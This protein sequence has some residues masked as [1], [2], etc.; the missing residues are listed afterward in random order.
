MA[1]INLLLSAR[2]VVLSVP[3]PCLPLSLPTLCRIKLENKGH[4]N[5]CGLIFHFARR[6]VV[7]LFADSPPIKLMTLHHLLPKPIF[8]FCCEGNPGKGGMP[9]DATSL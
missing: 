6:R 3:S 1:A 9:K 2:T 5:H 7:Y 4:I 8:F